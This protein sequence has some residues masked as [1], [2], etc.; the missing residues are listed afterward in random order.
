MSPSSFSSFLSLPFLD[1]TGRRGS[2]R[3]FGRAMSWWGVA[4]RRSR[5]VI[6]WRVVVVPRAVIGWL[7]RYVCAITRGYLSLNALHSDLR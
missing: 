1:I 7:K 2:R 5:D 6:P 4:M 3:R